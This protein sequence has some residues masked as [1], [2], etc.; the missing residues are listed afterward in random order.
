MV[1]S[2]KITNPYAQQLD[3]MVCDAKIEELN[4]ETEN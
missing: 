4:E 3:R 1:K 2:I